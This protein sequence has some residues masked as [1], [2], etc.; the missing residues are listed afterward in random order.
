M[1]VPAGTEAQDGSDRIRRKVS[2][3]ITLSVPRQ[4]VQRARQFGQ[5]QDADV[6]ACSINSPQLG[7]E[8][9]MCGT[10]PFKMQV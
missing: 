8:H 7:Q 4:A 2:L 6:S 10:T 3:E 5:T 9:L 1:S